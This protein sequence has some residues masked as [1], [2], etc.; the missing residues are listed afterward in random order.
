MSIIDSLIY[1]RTQQDLLNETDK[2]YISY[3]DLNRIEGA[4]KYLSDLLNVYGYK[5]ITT[6]KTEW[7]INEIRKQ[8]DCDRIKFNYE[9]LKNAYAYK[10]NVPAFN[11]STIQEANNIEKILADIEILIN[12]MEAVFRYS[13]TF[14]AGGMEGLI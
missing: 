7:K 6:N 12:K 4:V 2:A 11:W 14:N 13:N 10:F 5:N 9:V 1:D 3:I 8:E